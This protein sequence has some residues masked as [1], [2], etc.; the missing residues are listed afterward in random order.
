MSVVS[1]SIIYL[2][3]GLW[4]IIDLQVIDKSRVQQLFYHS[5]TKFV[6]YFNHFLAA[7]GTDIP[8]FSRGLGSTEL[9]ML[10]SGAKNPTSAPL[11]TSS[12]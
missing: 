3:L 5:I 1:R 7:Q 12:R 9:R 11:W 10:N 6:L 2:G 4:Q 8:V